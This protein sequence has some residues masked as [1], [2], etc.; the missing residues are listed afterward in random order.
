[1]SAA[2]LLISVRA[3]RIAFA[4]S[5]WRLSSPAHRC[6]RTRDVDAVQLGAIWNPAESVFL[7]FVLA[8][9]IV[10]D[11]AINRAYRHAGSFREG[12]LP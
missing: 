10:S 8:E 3:D 7:Q 11:G 5:I 1:M 9:V 4:Y 2:P 12:N 6:N